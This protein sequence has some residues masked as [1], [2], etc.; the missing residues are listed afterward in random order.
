MHT[1]RE[2]DDKRRRALEEQVR[3][4]LQELRAMGASEEELR[5]LCREEEEK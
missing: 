4:L 5:E 3:E 2:R 1:Y